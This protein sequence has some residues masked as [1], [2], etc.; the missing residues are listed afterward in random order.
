MSALSPT[1]DVRKVPG[2]PATGL[3]ESST[4]RALVTKTGAAG[5]ASLSREVGCYGPTSAASP[6]GPHITARRFGLSGKRLVG[7]GCGSSTYPL[8]PFFRVPE[9]CAEQ[10]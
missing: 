9:S 10:L 5:R 7:S 3:G 1:P 4:R 2:F 6:S 8:Y